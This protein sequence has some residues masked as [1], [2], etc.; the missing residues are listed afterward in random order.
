MLNDTELLAIEGKSRLTRDAVE[1]HWQR[2]GK[3][4][5]LLPKYAEMTL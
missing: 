1:Q 2:L 4:K 3:L 5:R